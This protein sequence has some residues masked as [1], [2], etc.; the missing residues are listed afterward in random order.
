MTLPSRPSISIVIFGASGDLC[1]KKLMPALFK[2]RANGLLENNLK[3]IGYGRTPLTD[4]SFRETLRASG[5]YPAETRDFFEKVFYR[6]GAYDSPEDFKKMTA[7]LPGCPS[8][9]LF[10]LAVPSDHVRDICRLIH[11]TNAA[12]CNDNNLYSRIIFE[13]PF[14]SDALSA[15]SLND[16]LLN[17][18]TEEQIFRI[19]HY[20][21]K[22]TVQNIL[23]F[24]FANNIFEP[25]WNNHYIEYIE[26]TISETEGVG[27]RGAY[28]DKAG[29]VRDMIQNHALQLLSLLMME[30]PQNFDAR[31][32][33]DEK[34][35]F[36]QSLVIPAEK[37]IPAL[38]VR[39]QYEG[40]THEKGVVPDSKTETFVAMELR[41]GNLRWGGTPIY[42]RVGKG[43]SEKVTEV[44]I[45]FKKVPHRMF[46][47]SNDNT[48]DSNIITFRIQPHEGIHLL[49]QTKRPG[50]AF[51]LAPVIM[52]FSY[53][54][55]FQGPTL[56]AYERLLLDAINGDQSLFLRND[57]VLAS[58]KI[59][60]AFTL[61][62]TIPLYFYKKGE[63]GPRAMCEFM[64][65]RKH[66]W[67]KGICSL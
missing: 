67:N 4:Q 66:S 16:F 32:I 57:E 33:R 50:L 31:C 42:L 24:R 28:F 34:L 17:L 61:T 30:A 41:I 25:L 27:T 56:E 20:L 39:G 22:E 6:Q 65:L 11:A 38:Y 12:P 40:Y 45:Y 51:T 54:A 1:R 29:I 13:K 49:F 53:A 60:D 62:S 9:R 46:G 19:D 10:Y 44:N 37:E 23:A 47:P 63:D 55:Q 48:T 8:I 35:K 59:T 15:K 14:G 18:F 58:W 43:L 36:L 5:N 21:G 26:M 7:E 52:D 3:I 2:L 64:S